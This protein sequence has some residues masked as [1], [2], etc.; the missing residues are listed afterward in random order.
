MLALLVA[1]TIVW[2]TSRLI[3]RRRQFLCEFAS[4]LTRPQLEQGSPV[5][6]L[7]RFSE[8]LV[9]EFQGRSVVVVLKHRMEDRLGNLVVAMKTRGSKEPTPYAGLEVDDLTVQIENGWLKATWMPVGFFTFPGRFDAVKWRAVLQRLDA[10]AGSLDV[11]AKSSG[12]ST[13]A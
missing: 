2:F 10:I 13:T 11:E 4:L 8:S 12:T 3:G 5:F 7:F 6:A 1:G 9:G